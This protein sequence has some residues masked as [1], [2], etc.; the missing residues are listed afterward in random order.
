M[1]AIISIYNN[2][3]LNIIRMKCVVFIVMI[4]G[5]TWSIGINSKLYRHLGELQMSWEHHI[6]DDCFRYPS[7][8]MCAQNIWL[9]GFAWMIFNQRDR[10]R[11]IRLQNFHM[12]LRYLC[13][14]CKFIGRSTPTAVRMNHSDLRIGLSACLNKHICIF[15]AVF[16]ECNRYAEIFG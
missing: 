3:L 14:Y 6:I 9:I 12:E 2:T 4:I 15:K 10:P 16:V 11:H 7:L 1:N 8:H 5:G 13:I